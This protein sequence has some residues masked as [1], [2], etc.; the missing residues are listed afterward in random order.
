MSDYRKGLPSVED[1]RAH[2]KRTRDGQWMRRRFATEDIP[3]CG[4]PEFTSLHSHVWSYILSSGQDFDAWEFRPAADDGHPMPW[5]GEAD[6]DEA[7]YQ[8]KRADDAL[9]LLRDEREAW[10]AERAALVERQTKA[11]MAQ[12]EEIAHL[13]RGIAAFTAAYEAAVSMRPAAK[14]APIENWLEEHRRRERIRIEQ[15]D[16]ER[17]ERTPPTTVRDWSDQ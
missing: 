14:K 17:A 13:R 16:R 6:S 5:P 4:A 15:E 3:V 10:R 1:V 9:D 2:E 11:L 7:A 12:A 8:A